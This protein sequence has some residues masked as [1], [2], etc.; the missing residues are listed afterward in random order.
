MTQLGS[1]SI[2]HMV[3]GVNSL[4]GVFLPSWVLCGIYVYPY[5]YKLN[6]FFGWDCLVVWL[7]GWYFEIESHYVSLTGLK[8]TKINL[9]VLP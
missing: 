6:K 9:T 1:V 4:Q 5:A 7:V 8:P 3:E 2:I